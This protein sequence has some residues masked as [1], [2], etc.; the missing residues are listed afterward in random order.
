MNASQVMGSQVR[1]RRW[2][3]A[4]GWL[5]VALLLWPWAACA[6]GARPRPSA[7]GGPLARWLGP[8]GGLAAS[9]EWVRFTAAVG[10]GADAA[11]AAHA[12][13]ALAL[14]PGA[15]EGWLFYAQHL[16]FD[17]AATMQERD[18]ARRTAAARAG[19]GVLRLGETRARE[20]GV[21]ALVGGDIALFLAERV[22]LDLDWEGG[23]GALLDAADAAYARAATYGRSDAAER[24][25]ALAAA[26]RGLEGPGAR[27][28]EGP[29][30]APGGD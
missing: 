27:T 25:A 29:A 4:L 3:P 15:A 1:A 12:A 8:L 26:R 30:A 11:A 24:R 2:F 17:R 10:R 5:A 22:P 23:A 20:P 18:R 21:L 19:L 28:P 16:V 6:D 7:A 13:R 9:V 14:D